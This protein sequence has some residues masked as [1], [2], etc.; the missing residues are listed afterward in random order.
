MQFSMFHIA[1]GAGRRS[2]RQVYE[3]LM[4]DVR[5]AE[6]LGFDVFFLA[7]HHFKSDFCMSPSPNVLLGAATAVTTRLKIGTAVSVLPLH[8]PTRLA[9]EVA[10]LDLL[11]NGRFQWGIGR[12]F[13]SPESWG[14]GVKGEETT[15]R[16]RE[17]HDAVLKAWATG[18]KEYHGTFYD[19]PPGPIAP[20][21][22]QRPHPPIWVSAQSP[23]SVR[24]SAEH[25]Y[26]AMQVL[27]TV[28]RGRTQLELYKEA[29]S[30]AGRTP[31]Q[32]GA[33]VPLRYVFIGE[34]EADVRQVGASTLMGWLHGFLG[35]AAPPEARPQRSPKS[36]ESYR[37]YTDPETSFRAQ[38]SAMT[39]EELVDSG[40]ILVGTPD[41][42]I[43]QI[44]RQVDELELSHMLCDFWRAGP[45]TEQRQ[46]SIRLFG[47]AVMPA[48]AR[49]ASPV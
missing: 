26:P 33:I 20:A 42:V 35:V 17:V 8:H 6:E 4:A 21:I 3:D 28:R 36:A 18:D 2:D 44:E 22:T 5:L 13:D 39:F 49:D 32:R 27:E 16:F 48:F 23:S 34:T 15:A 30:A 9:E 40:V 10:E 37:Y 12:G 19:L 46:R 11:S 41:Q 47:E 45:D 14:F 24:W 25:G 38:L 7:E 29:A 31:D 43:E 1:M